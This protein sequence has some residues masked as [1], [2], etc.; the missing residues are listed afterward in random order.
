MLVRAEEQRDCAAV[1]A[2]NAA[3]IETSGE[4]RLVARLREEAEPVVSLVAEEDDEVVG[5]IMFSLG[6]DSNP[7]RASNSFVNSTF[8]TKRLWPSSS[9]RDS[10]LTPSV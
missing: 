5:H 10:W 3:A 1:H 2:V 6:S 4:A 9:N 7:L 8:R